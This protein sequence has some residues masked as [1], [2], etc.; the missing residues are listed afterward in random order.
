MTIISGKA[1]KIV[2][3][4]LSS[5][6]KILLVS[7]RDWSGN[8]LAV[9]YRDSFREQFFE[10][11]RLIGLRY[12]GS[13]DIAILSLLNEVKDIF[14]ESQAVISIYK[15]CRFMLLPMPSYQALIGVAV[16]RSVV[17]EE[18]KEKE[19]GYNIVNKIERLMAD[20]LL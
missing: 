14:G 9:K 20:T 1:E 13:L 15:H 5:N 6:D 11:S 16:K 19:E 7:I 2:D 17:T 4:I 12:A 18:E 3:A 8:I 10:V